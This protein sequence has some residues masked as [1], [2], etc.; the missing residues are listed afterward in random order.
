[1]PAIFTT[2]GSRCPALAPQCSNTIDDDG[3]GLIDTLDPACHSDGNAGNSAT[4]DPLDN[5]EWSTPPLPPPP[6]YPPPP[7]NIS[8]GSWEEA[9]TTP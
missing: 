4:Y 6:V 2:I 7:P 5:D 1:M 3:D 8:I 9:T